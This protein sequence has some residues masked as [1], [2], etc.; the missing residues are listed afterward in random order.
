MSTA[1]VLIHKEGDEIQDGKRYLV[2]WKNRQKMAWLSFW[3]LIFFTFILWFVLPVW[4]NH[5]SVDSQKWTV[6]I[7]NS[8]EW[9]YITLGTVIIGYMGST[10]YILGGKKIAVNEEDY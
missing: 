9:L 4:Y 2:R 8:A 7:T 1:N 6:H 10:A 3:F 5:M